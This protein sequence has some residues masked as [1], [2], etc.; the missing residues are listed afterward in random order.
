M[1]AILNPLFLED[2]TSVL[3][4]LFQKI[5]NKRLFWF[6]ESNN[7][8]SPFQFGFRKG[9]NPFQAIKDLDLQI[10]KSLRNDTNLY[11]IFF[12]LQEAFSRVSTPLHLL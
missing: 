2:L 11:T 7:I 12:D 4:T 10:E 6:L 1:K 8:L 3:G 9:R 5:L